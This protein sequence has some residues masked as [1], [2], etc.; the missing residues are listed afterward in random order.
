METGTNQSA[1][2]KVY[3]LELWGDIVCTSG[4]I[5]VEIGGVSLD[6]SVLERLMVEKEKE[7]RAYFDDEDVSDDG[8]DDEEDEEEY[9]DEECTYM[10]TDYSSRPT[11]SI[12]EYPL[13]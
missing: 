4:A 2:T 12:S 7:L 6:R 9:E 3:V 13:L 8:D 5:I 1:P 10:N 11:W